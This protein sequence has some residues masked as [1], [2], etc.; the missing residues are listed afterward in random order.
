MVELV[1]RSLR[2]LGPFAETIDSDPQ[3]QVTV[4][5]KKGRAVLAFLAAHDGHSAS[6]DQL[7]ALL[8]GNPVDAHP[9]QNLRQCLISLRTDLTQLAP[10]LLAIDKDRIT[11]RT[12]R[13]SIDVLTLAELA[14]SN[15][16]PVLERAAALYSGQFL[17]DVRLGL[18]HFDDWLRVERCRIDALAAHVFERCADWSDNLGEGDRAI[19]AA[20]RLLRLDPRREDW[21]RLLL[22]L[23]ARYRGC[24][25]A[26]ARARW[27]TEFLRRDFADLAPATA[28]LIADIQHGRIAQARSNSEVGWIETRS[29]NSYGSEGRPVRVVGVNIDITE[30]KQAELALAE[31]NAQLTLAGNVARVGYFAYDVET[32][33]VAI[34]ENYA[35]IYGWPKGT[36]QMTVDYWRTRVHP[37]D[38]A[39]FDQ[40]RRRI[41]ANRSRDHTCDFRIIRADGEIRWIDSRRFISYDGEGHPRRIIG[42]NIDVTERKHTEAL[43]KETKARLSDALAA[44]QVVAFEWDASSGLSQRSDNAADILGS[45]DGRVARSRG[46]DFLNHIHPDDRASL[47]TRIRELRPG[48]PSYV[49]SFRYVRPDGRQV[50]LEEIAKGEFDAAGKLL[51]IKGLTRDITDRKCAEVWREFCQIR[52]RV[53]ALEF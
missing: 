40:T 35:A 30:R 52:S 28:T 45:G 17:A 51:R 9:R 5:S 47:K 36:T 49:L 41:F 46:S 1:R 21:Q 11:L 27:L 10:D 37:D 25:A 33:L 38:L 43:L 23:Y 53:G 48:D 20:T 15:D 12:E 19:D 24:D 22:R 13:L 29:F 3:V 26:A 42:V 8:W 18:K 14:K 16:L 44:G 39:Q 6:R 2:L 50:W 7:I 34:S 4:R 32:R 31:T